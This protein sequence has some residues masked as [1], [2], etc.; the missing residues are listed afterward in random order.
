MAAFGATTVNATYK[1]GR[2]STVGGINSVTQQVFSFIIPASATV[3]GPIDLTGAS[4]PPG[5]VLLGGVISPSQSLGTTKLA[6]NTKTANVTFS[7]ATAYTAEAAIVNSVPVMTPASATAADVI[8]CTTSVAT[9]PATDTTVTVT[10]FLGCFGT[11]V[12][13]ST[14]VGN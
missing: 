2:K 4:V 13:R 1:R 9:A 8:Q 12:G 14:A 7:A 11:E 3:A 10:L 5:A 6:F